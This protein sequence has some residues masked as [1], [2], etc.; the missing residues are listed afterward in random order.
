MTV[1]SNY[2][3]VIA[4][5]SDWLKNLVPGFQPVRSKP[6]PIS[7]CMHEFAALSIS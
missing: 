6:K 4:T 1:E 3:T 7:P 2:A 5:L